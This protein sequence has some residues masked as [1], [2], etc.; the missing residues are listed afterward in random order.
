MR[1]RIIYNFLKF[2]IVM[3]F[4][5][6]MFSLLDVLVNRAYNYGFINPWQ[7]SDLQILLAEKCRDD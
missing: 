7:Y 6:S 3:E 2:S 4:N 5:Y 1:K